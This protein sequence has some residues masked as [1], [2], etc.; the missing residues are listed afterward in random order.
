MESDTLQVKENTAIDSTSSGRNISSKYISLTGKDVK[1]MKRADANFASGLVLGTLGSWALV[2][3]E[4]R[5]LQTSLSKSRIGLSLLTLNATVVHFVYTLQ[6]RERTNKFLSANFNTPMVVYTHVI[7]GYPCPQT[8]VQ[9]VPKLL[10]EKPEKVTLLTLP[11]YTAFNEEKFN[12]YSK[13]SSTDSQLLGNIRKEL[14]KKYIHPSMA[15]GTSFALI[16]F[17][18]FKFKGIATFLALIYWSN[19]LAIYLAK[20]L[21]IPQFEKNI[22]HASHE[23]LFCQLLTKKVQEK[24]TLQKYNLLY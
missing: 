13:I 15:I 7:N 20:L 6:K 22:S 23:S 17:S 3:Q 21:F 19:V 11:R 24:E 12:I 4:G 9:N 10:D 8:Y 18:R 1:I 14:K 16:S 2:I 5:R